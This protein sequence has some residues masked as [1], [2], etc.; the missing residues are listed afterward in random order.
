MFW[1]ENYN[2]GALGFLAQCYPEGR[3]AA[4]QDPLGQ[5]SL[6]SFRVS[7]EVLGTL[8]PGFPRLQRGLYGTYGVTGEDRPFLKRWDPLVNFTFRDLPNSSAPLK[9]HWAGRFQA[10]QTGDYSFQVVTWE[11]QQARILVDG[12]GNP[13]F[14]FSPAFPVT[15]KAG[16]HRLDLDFQKGDYPI[17]AVN[18]LWKRPGQDRYEFMPND[19]FGPIGNKP[20]AP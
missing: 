18:L 14:N 17:A 4:F 7:A 6:Y 20:P 11:G 9:I 1:E 15:L 12:A 3:A 16:W 10:P 2:Q 13:A 5:S 8:K 19:V